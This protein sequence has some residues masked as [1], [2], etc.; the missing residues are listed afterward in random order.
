MLGPWTTPSL[1]AAKFCVPWNPSDQLIDLYNQAANQ[2]NTDQDPSLAAMIVVALQ[3]QMMLYNKATCTDCATQ[4]LPPTQTV[5]LAGATGVQ[6]AAP[7][8]AVF[9]NATTEEVS[10]GIA[11][12]SSLADQ[13]SAGTPAG[14]IV[15][16][17]TNIIQSIAGIFTAHHAQ[18]VALEQSMNCAVCY[19]FNKY[20]PQY[21]LAVAQGVMSADAALAAVMQII[22]QQLQPE[23]SDVISAHNIGWA[24]NQILMAHIW[25]RQQWYPMLESNASSLAGGLGSVVGSVTSNPTLLIVLAALAAL[26]F[27]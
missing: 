9:S 1:A 23:L 14:P 20:I 18:A 12:A 25:F 27:L 15:Q 19:A 24:E 13:I 11:E 3:N 4:G 10:G 2:F 7:S 6:T 5:I 22:Q 21:D 16:G 26:A 8:G 17:V